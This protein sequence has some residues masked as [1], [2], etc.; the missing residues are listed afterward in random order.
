MDFKIENRIFGQVSI[1]FIPYSYPL[2]IKKK[3]TRT[4]SRKKQKTRKKLGKT[5]K[6]SKN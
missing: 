3:K 2:L 5:R 6:R 1:K 4:K